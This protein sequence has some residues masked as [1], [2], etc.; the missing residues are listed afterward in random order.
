MLHPNG[1]FELGGVHSFAEILIVRLVHGP[2]FGD[3]MMVYT[4]LMMSSNT[5]GKVHPEDLI[6]VD[7]ASVQN[8]GALRFSSRHYRADPVPGIADATAHVNFRLVW[9]AGA[10]DGMQG[11]TVL[12]DQIEGGSGPDNTF[13]E[14]VTKCAVANYRNA[15]GAA[16]AVKAYLLH[17]VIP[18]E[19]TR[20]KDI[21]SI[22]QQ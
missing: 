18:A 21:L 17:G 4:T 10:T 1:S 22:G 9:V 2:G 12:F 6:F 11:V 7:F 3:A 16:V 13:P 20:P 5:T 19:A 14:D 8:I 15:H